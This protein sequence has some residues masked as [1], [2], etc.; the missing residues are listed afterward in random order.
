MNPH[1]ERLAA[2]SRHGGWVGVDFD[3]TLSNHGAPIPRMV[4]RVKA[5]LAAGVNVRIF[6]ARSDTDSVRGIREWCR[7]HLGAWLPVTDR[8]DHLLIESW[9]DRSVQVVPNTGERADGQEG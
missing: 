5:W 2:L 7:I 8:K 9:D 4:E 6:T 1:T 3:G